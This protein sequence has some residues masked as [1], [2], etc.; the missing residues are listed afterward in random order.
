MLVKVL[1]HNDLIFAEV[2]IKMVAIGIMEKVDFFLCINL[3]FGL[4][5]ADSALT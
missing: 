3:S 5:K 1:T 2:N 4:L